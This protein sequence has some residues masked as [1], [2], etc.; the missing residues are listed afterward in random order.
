M[1]PDICQALAW[2]T[3]SAVPRAQQP[4]LLSRLLCSHKHPM[5]LQ[6]RGEVGCRLACTTGADT[7][8]SYRRNPSGR[9][10][11]IETLVAPNKRSSI[12]LRMLEF[13]LFPLARWT[14]ISWWPS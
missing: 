3:S 5:A 12:M 8:T 9:I 1:F 7:M 14:W 4:V 11:M 2:C 6:K 10:S 13:V